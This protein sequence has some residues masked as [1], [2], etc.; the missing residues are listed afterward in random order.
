MT[1]TLRQRW[2]QTARTGGYTGLL[3]G[4]LLLVPAV[5]C[6]H[7]EPLFASPPHFLSLRDRQ[8]VVFFINEPVVGALASRGTGA[9]EVVEQ[10]EGDRPDAGARG[11]RVT[12]RRHVGRGAFPSRG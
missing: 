11:E 5:P 7:A 2:R 1:W 6:L 9:V 10:G 8:Q 3:V 12:L 4:T